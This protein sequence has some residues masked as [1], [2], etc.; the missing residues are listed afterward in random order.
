[1]KRNFYLLKLKGN[2]YK[3]ISCTVDKTGTDTGRTTYI[4]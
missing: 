2:V 1:M 4:Y 3:Y